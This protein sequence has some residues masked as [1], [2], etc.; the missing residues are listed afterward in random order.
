MSKLLF[1]ASEAFP[2]IKTGGLADVA[3]SLPEALSDNGVDVRLLIPAYHAILT[4]GLATRHLTNISLDGDWVEL[5]EA[6]VEGSNVIAWLIRHPDFSDRPGNPYHDEHHNA[7]HDNPARFSRLCKAAAAI[8]TGQAWLDWQPDILHC[9]DWHSGPAIALAKQHTN[10]PLTVLTIHNLRH[11]GNFDRY[12]F[13]QLRFPEALWHVNSG[14]FYGQ[15]SF[16]KAA[17][18]HADIITTV[19]PTYAQEILSAPGGMGLENVLSHRRANVHGITN[20]IDTTLWNPATDKALPFNYSVNNI[21]GK[22]RNKQQHLT[23]KGLKENPN[24]PLFGFIGR[25][26]EQKGLD[27]LLPNIER[28]AHSGAC[29]TVL[30]SGEKHYEYSLRELAARFPLQITVTIG[31]DEELAHQIEAAADVFLMPSLFEP[32]GLNQ[33]YSLRYGTLPVVRKVGGL[34]DTVCD[35]NDTT[36]ANGHATGFVFEEPSAHALWLSL[37]RVQALWQQPEKWQQVVINAMTQDVS[38]Q[39]SAAQYLKLYQQYSERAG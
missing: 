9:N 23:D 21:A 8:A 31:Y 35:T 7:W 13:D 32:C 4:S 18:S 38:W 34:A 12:T 39:Q 2:L 1:V 29:V 10:C 22:Y 5:L 16:L 19:S 14:E 20:G 28:L 36:A 27:I 26:D 30:G 11:Q 15:F 6:K 37:E 25:L 33:L 3:G 24:A 17:L